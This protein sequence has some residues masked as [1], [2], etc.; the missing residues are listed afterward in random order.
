M[1][2]IRAHF[3]GSVIVPD[4]PVNLPPQSQVVILL[5]GA[6]SIAAAD[7]ERATQKYYQESASDSEDSSWA[8]GAEADSRTAWDEE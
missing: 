1:V 8:Q 7:L 6:S 5:D 4:E 3:D 2:A